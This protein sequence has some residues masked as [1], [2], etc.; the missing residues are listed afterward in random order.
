MEEFADI[1]LDSVDPRDFTHIE[2]PLEMRV[3]ATNMWN[4][5]VAFRQQGFTQGEALFLMRT[6]GQLGQ[7]REQ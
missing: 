1:D 5:Y 7:S 3:G 2:V 6:M 4:M